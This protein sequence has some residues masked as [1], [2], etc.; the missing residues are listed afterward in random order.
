MKD[1]LSG[2]IL[3]LE[4]SWNTV[5]KGQKPYIFE[6]YQYINPGSEMVMWILLH[7]QIEIGRFVMLQRPGRVRTR[8]KML[9]INTDDQISVHLK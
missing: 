4:E 3:F 9:I 6:I 7:A 1:S 5:S 8:S 2:N